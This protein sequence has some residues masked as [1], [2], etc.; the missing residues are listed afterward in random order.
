MAR[1]MSCIL[2]LAVVALAADGL[3][4]AKPAKSP[5]Q[6][7]NHMD[8]D[9]DKKLSLDEFVGKRTDQKKQKATKRFGKLDKDG[10]EF[11]S[12]AEFEAGFKKKKK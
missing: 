1:L 4:A 9:Q 3:Q 7:F 2:A 12:L 5:E 10:D 6:R 11:L 8:K